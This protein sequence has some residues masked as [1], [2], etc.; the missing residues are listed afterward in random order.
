MDLLG[1]PVVLASLVAHRVKHLPA[2]GE[3]QARLPGSGK[4]H[5]GGNGNPP[6]Y[7]C[8]KIPRA[9]YSP[10]VAKCWKRVSDFTFTF[11]WDWN[12]N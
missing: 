10:W 3:T 6:H 5:G 4:S 12:E 7:S 8:W 1:Y 9:G 11:L 2:M